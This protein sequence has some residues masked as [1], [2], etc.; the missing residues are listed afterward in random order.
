[1][2]AISSCNAASRAQSSMRRLSG[3]SAKKQMLSAT[4]PANSWSSCMTT[5]I[6]ER[7]RVAPMLASDSPSTSNSPSVGVNRLVRILSSVVL[8]HPDAPTIATV[9]PGSILKLT[10]SSTQGSVSL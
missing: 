10:R 8:P 1:M 6:I 7:Q 9:S 4:D 5:P 2:A 3:W